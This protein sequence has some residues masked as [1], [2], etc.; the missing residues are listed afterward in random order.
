[1]DVANVPR[2]FDAYEFEFCYVDLQRGFTLA[3]GDFSAA[4]CDVMVEE[5]EA[6]C[7]SPEDTL[8]FVRGVR[9]DYP[10]A[11]LSCVL[12][13]NWCGAYF[14]GD[15]Q[16][17]AWICDVLRIQRKD[18]PVFGGIRD[19]KNDESLRL[20]I[21]RKISRVCEDVKKSRAWSA[22]ITGYCGC[23]ERYANER[24]AACADVGEKTISVS[25]VLANEVTRPSG[26]R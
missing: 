1:M 5:V 14:I 15:Y 8:L 4:R 22:S 12:V 25:S 16:L 13:W 21:E 24:R 26:S 18:G 11:A 3:S 9:R 6:A 17:G 19:E 10:E 2:E 7:P 23:I 20:Q